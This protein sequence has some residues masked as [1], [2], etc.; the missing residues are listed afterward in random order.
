MG[1]VKEGMKRKKRIRSVSLKEPS[2]LEK[3]GRGIKKWLALLHSVPFDEAESVVQWTLRDF[4]REGG[5]LH[6]H[7]STGPHELLRWCQ[8]FCFQSATIELNINKLFYLTLRRKIRFN[9]TANGVIR[10][11]LN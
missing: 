8:V 1:R 4:A 6:G 9:K 11:V 5:G 2:A 3:E 10:D 7:H